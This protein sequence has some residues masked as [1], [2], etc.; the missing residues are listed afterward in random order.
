M[1]SD[2]S[3]GS[4]LILLFYDPESIDSES[5]QS[6]AGSGAFVDISSLHRRKCLPTSIE[7][8]VSSN[9]GFQKLIS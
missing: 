2:H 9:V 1:D 4:S 7:E 8:I 3:Y 5:M 6:T